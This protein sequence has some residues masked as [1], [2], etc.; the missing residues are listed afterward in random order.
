MIEKPNWLFKGAIVYALGKKGVVKDCP[1]NEIK[2]K[3]YVYN[4]QVKLE[5]QK[6]AGTYHPS[7]LSE[8]PQA[9]TA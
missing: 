4:C 7:D 6:F 8:V 2:G 3:I 1:T 9:V 5:G